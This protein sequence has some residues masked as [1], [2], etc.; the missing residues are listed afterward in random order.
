[1]GAGETDWQGKPGE[2]T[3]KDARGAT[4][5]VLIQRPRKKNPHTTFAN[6]TTAS[7]GIKMCWFE[8]DPA[9]GSVVRQLGK[10]D[11]VDPDAT[12]S[13]DGWASSF[14]Q[15]AWQFHDLLTTGRRPSCKDLMAFFLDGRVPVSISKLD[16]KVVNRTQRA[17]ATL[18]KVADKEWRQRLGRKM[19]RV[20][21]S[22]I[23]YPEVR[24]MAT[25]R[26]KFYAG[27]IVRCEQWF[28]YDMDLMKSKHTW[29]RLRVF[30]DGS[31]DAWIAGCLAGFDNE[32]SAQI[33]IGEEHYADPETLRAMPE[34][35]ALLPA[36]QPAKLSDTSAPFRY[37]QWW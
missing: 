20:E 4:I 31:A 33:F 5:P 17:I 22:W 8:I 25:T 19:T 36:N 27:K 26:R 7:E 24:R 30:K 23:V 15:K 6:T 11:P 16:P 3:L 28:L 29:A 18:W 1:M 13:G 12:Y 14:Q 21:R 9:T 2:G 37:Y 34:F 10:T 35:T 32:Q